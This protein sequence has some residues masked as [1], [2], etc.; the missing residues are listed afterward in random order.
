MSVFISVSYFFKLFISVHQICALCNVLLYGQV[1]VALHV[2]V[3]VAAH[4]CSSGHP[5][6]RRF[7]LQTV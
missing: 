7:A 4:H 1:D 2:I 5:V 3:A 6:M